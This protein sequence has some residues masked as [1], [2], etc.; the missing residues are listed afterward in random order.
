VHWDYSQQQQAFFEMYF[1]LRYRFIAPQ[2]RHD[3]I[4]DDGYPS[5]MHRLQRELYNP[6]SP[7]VTRLLDNDPLLF[8]PAM[9]T[10]WQQSTPQLAIDAGLLGT[11]R[12]GKSYYLVTA[13]LALNPFEESVQVDL[14][15]SWHQW[16][17]DL[18]HRFPGLALTTTSV[19]RFAASTRRHMQQDM[20][21]IS[22][23]SLLGIALLTLTTFGSLLHLVIALLPLAVGLWIAVGVT[24]LIYG[25][26]HV[27]T[28]VFGASLIG[29][30]ID[31]S[32][33]YF[34][35]HR[36]S[37]PWIPL[38]A[39]RSIL[40]GLSLGVLT[41]I[42]SY[43]GLSLTPLVGLQQI[44]IFASCGI[45]VSFFTVVFVF[46]FLLN[47]PHPHAH[48]LPWL[49][50]S[51]QQVCM[52]WQRF[53]I[54]LY[55]LL[56]IVVLLSIKGL[57]TLHV[58]DTLQ[59]LSP[60]PADLRQHDRFIRDLVG[61]TQAQ[62]YL[63]VE[64]QTGEQALQQLEDFHEAIQPD[65][66]RYGLVWGPLLTSFLPSQR[67][68]H[69]DA[70]AVRR[71]LRHTPAMTQA[72]QGLGFSLE[73][74]T[75]LF[76]TIAHDPAPIL[77]PAAWLHHDVSVGLR[78]LWLGETS[79]GAALLVPIRQV[80]DVAGLQQAIAAYPGI[81]YMDQAAEFRRLLRQYRQRVMLLGSIAYLVILGLLLQRYHGRGCLIL[82][83]PSLAAGITVGLLSLFGQD[84]TLMHC[85]ALLL[86]L[87]MGV[88][89]TIFLTETPTA[90]EPTTLLALTLSAMTTALSFGLLSFSH[91]AMLKAI[92]LTTLIGICGAWA[93]APMAM[94]RRSR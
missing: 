92:G 50:Q 91:Q 21:I 32:F 58:D 69:E 60:P 59:A 55:S 49:Y 34:A 36:V 33:H 81:R 52:W 9:L 17:T 53:P 61:V 84:F 79:R 24:L 41:T 5:L 89:Y 39:M 4:Q 19:A 47:K 88:D 31:Y 83:P 35:H 67:R 16:T 13:K 66:A 15:N 94:S 73:S 7:F 74:I 77:M 6:T 72:L 63:I 54:R 20:V 18:R 11:R 1:P 26:I 2:L 80:H 3:L 82:L 27:F 75:R 23:G 56:G 25:E 38:V 43:A 93:L 12:N 65:E 46:P 76:Q 68:Q 85:L 30:C 44:A 90:S 8:F 40:P 51:A 14:E 29:I 71:L 62:R 57:L 86:V 42:V 48:T 64:G 70:Q 10:Q 45:L 37:V 87:G 28:L 22:V 78:D